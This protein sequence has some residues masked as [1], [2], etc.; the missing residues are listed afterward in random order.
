MNF[1]ESHENQKNRIF[2]LKRVVNQ[3]PTA[4]ERKKERHAF[5]SCRKNSLRPLGGLKNNGSL[6]KSQFDMLAKFL[7]NF[8]KT[9]AACS[10]SKTCTH[11]LLLSYSV[12]VVVALVQEQP[13]LTN[14]SLRTLN[15]QLQYN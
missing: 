11:T 10:S 2:A 4:Q 9:G 15:E 5:A 8:S 12:L 3:E 1:L 7:E 14:S 6:W 13:E